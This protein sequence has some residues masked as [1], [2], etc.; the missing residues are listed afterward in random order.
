MR[1]LPTPLTVLSPS[2]AVILLGALAFVAVAHIG[3]LLGGHRHLVGDQVVY[4]EHLYE[5][6]HAHSEKTP[7][8]G[9]RE[10]D[11]R[12]AGGPE[13]EGG[14]GP[15]EPEP[16]PERSQDQ[17]FSSPTLLAQVTSPQALATLISVESQ[18]RP[19]ATSPA[20]RRIRRFLPT[21]NRP[22]PRR[23]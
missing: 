5:G 13:E 12:L 10:R 21:A 20:E 1:R 14:R 7:R 8:G 2:A 15:Q 4:H 17:V 22:P 16:A 11:D 3:G 6:A 9:A 19:A 18:E 23:S